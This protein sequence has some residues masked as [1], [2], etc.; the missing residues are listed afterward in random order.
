MR[1]KISDF[2]SRVLKGAFPN[3]E[4]YT[5]FRTG[6]HG[7]PNCIEIPAF[8]VYLAFREK[9]RSMELLIA[10]QQCNVVLPPVFIGRIAY[11]IQFAEQGA[12]GGHLTWKDKMA[13]NLDPDVTQSVFKSIGDTE[14]ARRATAEAKAASSGTPSSEPKSFAP[15]PPP[16]KAAASG[17]PAPSS[18]TTPTAAEAK[19]KPPHKAMPAKAAPKPSRPPPSEKPQQMPQYKKTR[20][21]MN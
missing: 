13:P 2:V 17:K 8:T 10:A 14:S 1:V 12:Q 3:A 19:A 11:A 18:P 15:K 20:T 7:F 5:Y 21:D 9:E 16:T 6:D 4:H